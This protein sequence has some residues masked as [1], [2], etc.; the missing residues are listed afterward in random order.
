M[1]GEIPSRSKCDWLRGIVDARD[2]LRDAVLLPR[3][4]AD[5]HVVLVVAGEREHDVGRARDARPLEDEE[6][7]RVAALHLVLELVLERL[8]AV[9]PLLD[10][11]HL[12]AEPKKRAGDVRADLAAARDDDVHQTGSGVAASSVG[13]AV[14]IAHVRAASIRRS[15]ATLV[16]HTVSSPRSA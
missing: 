11:R 10:Q 14:G 13:C 4:L 16:G 8:E 12:V 15:M 6:L 7:G 3:D 2:D 5:D 9:A 1:V